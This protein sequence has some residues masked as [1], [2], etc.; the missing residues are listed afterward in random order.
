MSAPVAGRRPADHCRPAA[1]GSPRTRMAAAARDVVDVDDQPRLYA[2]LAGNVVDEIGG[3][4]GGRARISDIGAGFGGTD[5]FGWAFIAI[6]FSFLVC[7]R[8]PSD[9]GHAASATEESARGP[10]ATRRRLRPVPIR[11]Q[12]V[13]CL[14]YWERRCPLLTAGLV[15]A[16]PTASR[17][18]MSVATLARVLAAAAV[19]LPVVSLMASFTLALIQVMPRSR[20]PARWS[21]SLRCSGVL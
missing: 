7:A 12:A 13:W 8:P 2:L 17:R 15:A 4:I 1:V 20:R 19:Q 10:D 6:S 5:S 21:P 11:Q 3:G 18:G 9:L 16:W 14:S